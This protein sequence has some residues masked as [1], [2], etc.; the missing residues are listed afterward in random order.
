[1]ALNQ[2]DI[3]VYLLRWAY[4]EGRDI[5]PVVWSWD[6]CILPFFTHPV[7]GATLYNW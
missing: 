1:M 2:T 6:V 3:T 4:S 5:D 7:M